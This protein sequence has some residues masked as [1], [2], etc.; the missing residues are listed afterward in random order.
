MTYE[1]FIKTF[2]DVTVLEI[3]TL[4]LAV[5]FVIVTYRK[6]REYLANKIKEQEKSR[7]AEEKRDKDIK[8]ALD[9]IHKYPEYRQQSI[10][11][12]TKLEGQITELKNLHKETSERL[13]RME[14]DTKRRE[15]NKIRDRLLQNYR[16]YTNAE[17][18]PSHSWSKMEAEAFWDLFKEY[19]EAGGNGY[20][21]SE[22]RPAMELLTVTDVRKR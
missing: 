15:M 2:G 4:I 10:N 17:S 8:E 14:N 3:I 7:K 13:E 18:N 19:E 20:M 22:V 9:A 21:H 6:I 5:V 12:Q 16:Y 11:I 1:A